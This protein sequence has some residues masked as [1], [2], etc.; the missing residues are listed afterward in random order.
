MILGKG[1]W[2]GRM[3][4]HRAGS[5]RLV[6]A[7]AGT[8]LLALSM[9]E[10]ALADTTNE[11]EQRFDIP[12][13]PLRLAL[14]TF[15][16]QSGM[17]ILFA[18]ELVANRTGPGLHASC[19]RQVALERILAG[20][21]FAV[22]RLGPDAVMI[23]AGSRHAAK[24][25]ETA[26]AVQ[27][28]PKR[29][30][31][32]T[33]FKYPTILA[34]SAADL[35]VMPGA[36]LARR[37]IRDLRE[38]ASATPSLA[39]SEA[40][41]GAQRLTIRGVYGR[42]EATVGVYYGDAPVTGPSGTTFDPGWITPDQELVDIDRIELLR[43]PQGTLYGASSMGG[44]LRIHFNR[45]D[46]AA[47]AAQV[48]TGLATTRGGGA[49]Y[50][51]SAMLNL[52][53][54]KDRLAVRAV[55]YTRRIGGYIDQPLVAQENLGATDRIGGRLALEWKPG[56]DVTLRVSGLRQ[57]SRIDAGRFWNDEA[58]LY[59]S[60]VPVRMPNENTLTLG[61]AVLEVMTDWGMLT[62]SGTLYRWN[63]TRQSD[64]SDV[65]A[66]Q[67]DSPAACSRY[68]A[69]PAG[70]TCD[71]AQ[72]AAYEAY[73]SSRL[74]ALLYQPMH[75]TSA[76][77]ELRF[78]SEALADMAVTLGL[79][80]ER[81]RSR[82]DSITALGDTASGLVLK[83][84]DVTGFRT[85]H[86]GLDQFAVFGEASRSL[87]SSLTV[88]GGF[89]FF[90]YFREAGG[91]IVIPNLITGTADIAPGQF[92]TRENGSNYKA[93]LA[94]RPARGLLGYIQI[95][96]GFRPGGVNIT[97]ALTETERTYHADSLRSYE[98]GLRA[99]LPGPALDL[100]LAA[101]HID[102]SDMIYS[103]NSANSAFTYNTN[104]GDVD[105]DGVELGLE[106]KPVPGG[107]FSLNATW[108]DSRLAEN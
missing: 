106:W 73:A 64:F 31:M 63:V 8:P 19:G 65:I 10:A 30:I 89:R 74:P 104:V 24:A 17:Q 98:A 25:R 75:V 3:A 28:E 93:Q 103:A 22:R 85:I 34:E 16:R 52:P 100:Q 105:I 23:V 77:G 55:G 45:P 42:G 56:P 67:V 62:A 41:S 27:G 7:L 1:A 102:W 13:G 61:N 48:H 54:A 43:G 78:H 32:V 26:T 107:T 46:P 9:P 97:P 88:T 49:G 101:Y 40:S 6:A 21:G 68:N 15:A 71:A 59:L 37:E 81:R 2:R 82:V 99:H 5:L 11:A 36:S 72:W 66:G 57:A 53:L 83:P 38:L 70:G 50:N 29:D 39:M 84:L 60:D 108:T 92:T 80:A 47:A 69:L 96:D 86:T 79:F 44:T 33:A 95:A 90:H 20:S 14:L 4:F 87:T 12:A 91:E 76:N 18:P 58:G 94:W 51:A 35:S